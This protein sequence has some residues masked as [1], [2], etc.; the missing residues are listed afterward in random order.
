M[1]LK[2]SL[3]DYVEREFLDLVEHIW[4]VETDKRSHDELIS[5]FDQIVGHPAGS[6]LLFYSGTES[7]GAVNSP[8]YVVAT[9]KSWH[10][11][12][13]RVAFKGQTLQPP[14]LRRS[15]ARELRASQ[16]STRNLE[17]V[18]KLVAEIQAAEQRLAHHEISLG[19]P[20]SATCT[21]PMCLS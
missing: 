10:Q 18:R 19:H 21:C 11:R 17:K 2:S 7:F 15:P 8:G 14:R 13:G 4:N 1:E 20:A 3:S 9:I 12:N 5:H 16:S 6:D